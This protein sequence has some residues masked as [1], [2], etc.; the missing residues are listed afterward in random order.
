MNFNILSKPVTSN[1]QGEQYRWFYRVCE[2]LNDLANIIGLG[3][4]VPLGNGI[5]VKTSGDVYAART[6]TGTADEVDVADGSGVSGNPTI[7]LPAVISTPRSFGDGVN[8]TTFE[9]DGTMVA[10]NGALTW[11]DIF[12]PMGVPKTSTGAPIRSVWIGNIAGYS[13]AINAF[14]DA[15]PQ[16]YSHDG[17]V[18]STATLHIHWVSL[19]DVAALRYVKWQVEYTQV[20][21]T[22]VFPATT[23]VSIEIEI[24]ANTPVGKHFITDIA[25]FTTLGP[26]SF[27]CLQLKRIAASGTAPEKPPVVLGTHYHYEV[28]TLGSRGVI[29]K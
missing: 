26:A 29:T 24:P 16:E 13:F 18:G 21:P 4:L 3:N 25:T 5:V 9:A 11:K 6:I 1:S 8:Q 22:G 15:D 12:F 2:I 27:M 20:S 14:Y 19:T 7:S 17:K 23:T 28:D 10:E